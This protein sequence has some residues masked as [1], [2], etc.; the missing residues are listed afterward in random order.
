MAAVVVV[1]AVVNRR[2]LLCNA[3]DWK[4][5]PDPYFARL[6]GTDVMFDGGSLIVGLVTG[7]N[8]DLTGD[9][10]VTI[11]FCHIGD[12][13]THGFVP[14]IEF[15]PGMTGMHVS[16]VQKRSPYAQYDPITRRLY[17]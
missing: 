8:T 1:P 16:M 14:T 10:Y 5:I 6:I 12:W 13:I 2:M 7:Y 9:R 11:Q 15:D 17:K 4:A 3:G